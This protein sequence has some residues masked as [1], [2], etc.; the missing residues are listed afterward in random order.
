MPSIRKGSFPLSLTYSDGNYTNN[1]F[2]DKAYYDAWLNTCE[3][4]FD[5]KMNFRSRNKD[6][7]DYIDVNELNE[8]RDKLRTI[9]IFDSSIASTIK[10][11]KRRNQLNGIQSVFA[12]GFIPK[13]NMQNSQFYFR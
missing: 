11:K 3:L 7:N 8:K 6:G 4:S 1:L 5:L 9:Q 10:K 2:G 12:D 13:D